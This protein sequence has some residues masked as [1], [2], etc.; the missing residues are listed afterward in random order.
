[1]AFWYYSSGS[2]WLPFDPMSRGQIEM[3]WRHSTAA[4]VYVAAFRGPAYINAAALYM[5]YNGISYPIA[6][7]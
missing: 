7:R 4:W 3:L 6:R 2:A 5:N 1:M